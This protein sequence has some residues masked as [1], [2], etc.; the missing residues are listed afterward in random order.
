MASATWGRRTTAAIPG[1]DVATADG[2]ADG[3]EPCLLE[4]V[5]Y[6]P[7]ASRPVDNQGRSTSQGRERIMAET[8]SAMAG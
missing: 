8:F 1:H 2:D 3:F 5:K 6:Q 4:H 7:A